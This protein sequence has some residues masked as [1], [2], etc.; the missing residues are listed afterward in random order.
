MMPFDKPCPP[1]PKHKENDTRYSQEYLEW[2]R[3]MCKICDVN[4]QDGSCLIGLN[5]C[6]WN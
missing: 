1:P 3:D 6:K 2:L 4:G 5:S